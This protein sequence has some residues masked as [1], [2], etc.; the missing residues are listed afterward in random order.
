M[1]QEVAKCFIG[2]DPTFPRAAASTG[3]AG[4]QSQVLFS[5]GRG[6]DVPLGTQGGFYNTL[7]EVT[8]EHENRSVSAAG[9][10]AASCAYPIF[11]WLLINLTRRKGG[12][13]EELGMAVGRMVGQR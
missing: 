7:T 12:K 13:R 6:G 9:G 1:Q 3:R 5:A 10:S 4:V 2:L 8:L 11:A